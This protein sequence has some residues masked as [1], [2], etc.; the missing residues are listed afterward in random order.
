MN[1]GF[2]INFNFALA[3]FNFL[4]Y[5]KLNKCNFISHMP[6]IFVEN[7]YMI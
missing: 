5:S 7:L 2:T 1:F 3:F 4:F 6:F